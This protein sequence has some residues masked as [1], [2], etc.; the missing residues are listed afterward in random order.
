MIL[1]KPL[2][3]QREPHNAEASSSSSL[4]LR[5]CTAQGGLADAHMIH[6]MYEMVT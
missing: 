3:L 6:M 5:C 1:R 2:M 4:L